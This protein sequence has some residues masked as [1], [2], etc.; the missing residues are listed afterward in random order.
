MALSAECHHLS[1]LHLLHQCTCPASETFPY[2][3]KAL[4][5]E[6]VAGNTEIF[7]QNRGHNCGHPWPGGTTGPD[8]RYENNVRN[9]FV[10]MTSNFARHNESRISTFGSAPWGSL[11][12][13][14]LLRRLVYDPNIRTMGSV[15]ELG[16]YIS[17]TPL[18]PESVSGTSGGLYRRERTSPKEIDDMWQV[19][20]ELWH[21]VTGCLMG[22]HGEHATGEKGLEMTLNSE[23]TWLRPISCA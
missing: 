14:G 17:S 23:W 21:F 9:H 6:S 7:T 8:K 12:M 16:E 10:Q 20:R 1:L 18:A 4:H 19:T 3:G 11:V 22:G 5:W 13:D 15:N 2:E